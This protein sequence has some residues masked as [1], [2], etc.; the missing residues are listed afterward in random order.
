MFPLLTSPG[1]DLTRIAVSLQLCLEFPRETGLILMCARKVGNAFQ[2]G[3]RNGYPLQDSCLESPMDRGAWRAAVQGVTK[4]RTRLSTHTLVK[5][6]A[7]WEPDFWARVVN[8]FSGSLTS[9]S[10][11]LVFPSVP[12]DQ[13]QDRPGTRSLDGGARWHR[14]AAALNTPCLDPQGSHVTP[15]PRHALFP[16]FSGATKSPS[17]G[18]V[19]VNQIKSFCRLPQTMPGTK[20]H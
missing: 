6:R 4:S 16:H 20:S 15:R 12:E 7:R 13:E 3:E 5:G 1:P 19:K 8:S 10:E 9:D 14:L 18:V 2:P 17:R 11:G